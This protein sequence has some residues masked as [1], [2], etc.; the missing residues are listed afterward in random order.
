MKKLIF[1]V[2]KVYLSAGYLKFKYV[3]T[4]GKL[5]YFEQVAKNSTDWHKHVGGEFD[6]YIDFDVNYSENVFSLAPQE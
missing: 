3:G 4:D 1:E 5:N 2:G 6:G